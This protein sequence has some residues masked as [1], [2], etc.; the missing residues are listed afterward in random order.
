MTDINIPWIQPGGRTS[1]G[2]PGFIK[3]KNW[4][5]QRLSKGQA[6]N[7]KFGYVV[8]NT[9][10]MGPGYYSMESRE[11]YTIFKD[12]LIARQGRAERNEAR[13]KADDRRAAD[14]CC[15]CPRDKQTVARDEDRV[16]EVKTMRALVEAR[17]ESGSGPMAWVSQE[18][19]VAH[20]GEFPHIPR[21]NRWMMHR[22]HAGDSTGGY[23]YSYDCHDF[24]GDLGG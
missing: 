19:I 3:A 17:L 4:E 21:R 13:R 5:R 8:S 18:N 20:G 24:G 15:G 14:Q 23:F 10:S 2:K 16:R 22:Y 1:D 6:L 11:G 7:T 9:G 12:Q